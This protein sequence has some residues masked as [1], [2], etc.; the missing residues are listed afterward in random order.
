MQK[1][2]LKIQTFSTC[3][4]SALTVLAFQLSYCLQYF[5]FRFWWTK[6]GIIFFNFG[7]AL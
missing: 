6:C 7:W 5:I 4:L 2:Q 1:L 3:A